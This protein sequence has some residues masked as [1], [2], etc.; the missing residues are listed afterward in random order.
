MDVEL[1]LNTRAARAQF[2]A[3]KR[4]ILRRL[5]EA[6]AEGAEANA[7]RQSGFLASTVA[8]VAPRGPGVAARD[9]VVNGQHKQAAQ[10][11]A[12]GEDEVIVAVLALYALFLE[13]KQPFLFEAAL[14]A[15]ARLEAFVQAE[16]LR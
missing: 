15:S 2:H 14:R 12:A 13:L 3:A 6:T 8:S 7:P 10:L 5:G 9:E 4:G 1:K 11:R 16:A